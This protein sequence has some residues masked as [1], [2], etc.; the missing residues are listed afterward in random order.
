MTGARRSRGY[1]TLFTSKGEASACHDRRRPTPRTRKIVPSS[2]PRVVRQLMDSLVRH[3]Q[4]A[5]GIAGTH[6]QFPTTQQAH[7]ASCRTSRTAVFPIGLL[8][9]RGVYADGLRSG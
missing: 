6:L 3:A 5:G 8:A 4:Q 9:E 7:G 2:T 1:P